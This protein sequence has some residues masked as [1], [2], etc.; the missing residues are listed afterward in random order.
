M[1][2][3]LLLNINR[4]LSPQVPDFDKGWRQSVSWWVWEGALMLGLGQSHPPQR[5]LALAQSQRRSLSRVCPLSLREDNYRFQACI[6][7]RQPVITL[8]VSRQMRN[9]GSSIDICHAT[10]DHQS[11]YRRGERGSSKFYISLIC[12]RS[13]EV[14]FL[15]LDRNCCLPGFGAVWG[16]VALSASIV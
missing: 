8:P 4:P 13:F 6:I 2:F 15:L 10:I 12:P 16:S 14:S 5:K 11:L 9:A 1:H 3:C 7:I